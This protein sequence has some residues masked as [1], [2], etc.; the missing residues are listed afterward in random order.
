[1]EVV[2]QPCGRFLVGEGRQL[3]RRSADLVP[4]LVRPT[5]AF[6]L[7]ERHRAG[8]PRRRRDEDAVAR[9]LLD[10]PR[11][12]T[13]QERLAGPRLVDH[14]LVELA[15]PAAAVDQEH[16]EE[17]AVGDRAGV[18]DG[19]PARAVPR[20]DRAARAVPDDARAELCEL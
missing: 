10:P 4:E 7:P 19:E 17:A 12:G 11:R 1:M 6:A 18:R 15:D 14:L 5:D 9:D 3:T 16:A 13:E 2:A 20:T 8:Q